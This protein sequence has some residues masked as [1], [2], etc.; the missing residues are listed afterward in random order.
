MFVIAG[1]LIKFQSFLKN[2]KI[3]KVS[4]SEEDVNGN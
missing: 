2:L 4:Q 3:Q 1:R